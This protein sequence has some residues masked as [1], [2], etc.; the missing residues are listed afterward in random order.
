MSTCPHCGKA[1]IAT[2]D[3]LVAVYA[4]L[5]CSCSSCRQVVGVGLRWRVIAYLGIAS[6]IASQLLHH[7]EYPLLAF[8]STPIIVALPVVGAVAATWAPVIKVGDSSCNT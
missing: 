2:S 4:G 7:A 5:T 6:P 1:S 8:F 3:K